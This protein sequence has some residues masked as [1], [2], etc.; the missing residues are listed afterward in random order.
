ML[1]LFVFYFFL[2]FTSKPHLNGLMA[3]CYW[4][5]FI[6]LLFFY[7][8]LLS[9]FGMIFLMMYAQLNLSPHSEKS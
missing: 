9:G 6:L 2:N 5:F 3:G 1:F 4:F 7:I 8:L